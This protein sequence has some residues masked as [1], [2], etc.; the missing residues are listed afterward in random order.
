[1]KRFM[2]HAKDFIADLITNRVFLNV[3]W[4]SCDCNLDNI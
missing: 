3:E 1:M 2:Y 4:C